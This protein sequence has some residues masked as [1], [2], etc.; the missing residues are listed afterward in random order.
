MQNSN[1]LI[2]AMHVKLGVIIMVKQQNLSQTP[3]VTQ[4]ITK[5]LC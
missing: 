5:L 1:A 3:E 4:L 2:Y